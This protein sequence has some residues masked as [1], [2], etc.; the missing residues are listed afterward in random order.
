LN[1]LIRYFLVFILL[2]SIAYP[3]SLNTQT[4]SIPIFKNNTGDVKYDWISETLSDMLTTDIASTD[5]IR[6]VARVELKEILAEQKLGLTGL[7]DEDT[8]VEVGKLVGANILVYGSF[9]LSNGILRIDTKIFDIEKGTIKNANTIQ[10]NMIEL[11]SLEKKMALQTMKGLGL[12]LSSEDK[13]RLLQFQSESLSAI[14]SN[15]KGVLELDDKNIES[16]EK[17]FKQAME[18]DPYYKKAALNFESASSLI[19][20][21]MS[22][23]NDIAQELI[24][25]E[26]QREYLD[27]IMRNFL[28]LY[29]IIEIDGMPSP[30]TSYDNNETAGLNIP[31]LI[32]INPDAVTMLVESLMKISA[33]E[34]RFSFSQGEVWFQENVDIYLYRENMDWLRESYGRK[35]K[36]TP[37]ANQ[38]NDCAWFEK[39]VT[40]GLFSR[41][42]IISSANISFS[43]DPNENMMA[44]LKPDIS[45]LK[46][47]SRFPR[48]Y[49]DFPLKYDLAT[50]YLPMSEIKKIT[51]VEIE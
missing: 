8:Q 9:T 5:K 23:F 44:L 22:I 12:K 35:C 25:K 42:N 38:A 48:T 6:V 16:A 36:Q 46:S 37:Y 15:Y 1:C 47:S 14:E 13:F 33:G 18:F 17:Y 4:L 43:V 50:E 39:E 11:L 34:A 51:R 32:K 49:E 41:D 10:G 30:I 24:R 2:A 26:K 20:S 27:V 21:G 40:I 3:Q 45:V 19:V 7:L 28:D 31:L 29:W